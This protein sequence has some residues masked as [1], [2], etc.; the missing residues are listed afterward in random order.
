MSDLKFFWR[1]GQVVCH[2]RPQLSIQ[3]STPHNPTY[4][5]VNTVLILFCFLLL[6]YCV[7]FQL[8]KIEKSVPLDCCRLVKFDEYQDT[9][10][11]SFENEDDTPMGLLLGGVK[12]A[13]NFD[14]LLETKRPEQVFQEYRP[15]GKKI[16][17]HVL[18]FC[19]LQWER[20]KFSQHVYI[21]PTYLDM[22]LQLLDE[23]FQFMLFHI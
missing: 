17:I 1:R 8:F 16:Y 22:I 5:R 4:R 18:V 12:Q 10:E 15:G 11:C 20:W 19:W 14:L 23:D 2:A 21:I 6:I 3:F 9:L 13:Y 7:I